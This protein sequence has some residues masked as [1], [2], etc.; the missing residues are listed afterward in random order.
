[1]HFIIFFKL[2]LD[3]VKFMGI[4]DDHLIQV[5][6]FI[7]AVVFMLASILV[8]KKLK[9]KGILSK[10]QARKLIHSLG[11][12]TILFGP[13]LSF[14]YLIPGVILFIVMTTLIYY[15]SPNSS[16][17][18]FRDIFYAVSDSEEDQVNYLKGPFTYNLTITLLFG[19]FLFMRD[20]F[21]FPIT[22]VLIMMYSD[23]AASIIGR[24]YG[25]RRIF[26]TSEKNKR[27]YIGSLTF[28]IVSLICGFAIYYLF[29]TQLSDVTAQAPI[30][31]RQ[32]VIY[33]MITAISATLVEMISPS[34]YDDL[35]VPT[36]SVVVVAG[37]SVMLGFW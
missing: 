31:F 6:L 37:F 18:I 12:L 33:T 8:P 1:M 4:L 34:N 28:F 29:G 3:D 22:G 36:A 13:F 14:W 11:G 20:H 35:I 17:K 32:V 15:S 30:S 7:S 25:N 5:S 9:E 16:V 21:Y 26:P 24:R 2:F 19:I 23:T 10:F 27:T